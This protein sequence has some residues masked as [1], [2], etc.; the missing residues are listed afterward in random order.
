MGRRCVPVGFIHLRERGAMMIQPAH[1]LG[2]GHRPAAVAGS[3][4]PAHAGEL[5]RTIIRLMDDARR[6]QARGELHVGR[7]KALIVP[8]GDLAHAGA[9]AA[10]AYAYITP[11][12]GTI[13]RVVLVGPAHHVPVFGLASTSAEAFDT[14][15]GSVTVDREA[16]ERLNAL[17]HVSEHDQAH[18]PEHVL[19][20][21]LPFLLHLLGSERT[22]RGAGSG[23]RIVPLLVGEASDMQV[24]HTLNRV[25]GG[26]ETLIVVSS[27]LSRSVER[28]ATDRRNRETAR[29]ILDGRIEAIGMQDACGHIAIRALM[30]LAWA[31]RIHPRLLE[32]GSTG[33]GATGA[34]TASVGY[35]SFIYG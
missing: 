2:G 17:P 14:P 35:G 10:R 1:Y 11:M 34:G 29:H 18:Q 25:W 12:H 31:H 23:F 9:V 13:K 27:D 8:H 20:V 22:E 32:L 15:L 7:P 6:A 24:M 5:R 21:H 3:F 4:Y 19:E 33:D 28:H 16:V 30:H 26:Q